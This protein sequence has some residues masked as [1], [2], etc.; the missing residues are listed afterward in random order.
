[1]DAP[2]IS[3]G[4][5]YNGELV[6][7]NIMYEGMEQPVVQWTPSIAVCPAEFCNSQLFSKWKNNLFIGALAF[8]EIRRLIIED[9]QVVDQEIILKDFG[10]VREIKTRRRAP[11]MYY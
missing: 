1:M 8:E 2:V 9:N 3:Y 11:C 5:D 6:T 10:R 7:E 4:I